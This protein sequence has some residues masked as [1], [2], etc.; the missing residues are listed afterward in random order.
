MISKIFWWIVWLWKQFWDPF[1]IGIF[2]HWITILPLATIGGIVLLRLGNGFGLDRLFWN[3]NRWVR[4]K[5]GFAMG[6]LL[7]TAFVVGLLLDSDQIGSGQGGP[8]EILFHRSLINFGFLSLICVLAGWIGHAFLTQD[9]PK[10]QNTPGEPIRCVQE[11]SSLPLRG[12]SNGWLL[13]IGFAVAMI[14][15]FAFLY[16]MS[17][18]GQRLFVH[19]KLAPSINGSVKSGSL[20]SLAHL[21]ESPVPVMHLFALALV[22]GNVAYWLWRLFFGLSKATTSVALCWLAGVVIL[23][24]GLVQFFWIPMWALLFIFIALGATRSQYTFRLKALCYCDRMIRSIGDAG[25]EPTKLTDENLAETGHAWTECRKQPLVIVCCTGGGIRSAV[26]TIRCLMELE[27]QIP[28]FAGR[29]RLIFGA[30]GGMLGATRYVTWRDRLATVPAEPTFSREE[31]IKQI[32][33]DGLSQMASQ[34]LFHD[35]PQAVVP[36]IPGKHRGTVIEE[37]W[38]RNF[39]TVPQDPQPAMVVIT[40]AIRRGL[41]WRPRMVVAAVRNMRNGKPREPA[42]DTFRTLEQNER[43]GK[44]PSLVYSPMMIEDGRRMLFSNLDLSNLIQNR[45]PELKRSGRELY[46]QSAV[47]FRTLFKNEF[48]AF[49]LLSAVRLNASFPYVMPASS[50]PTEPRRRLVD[51][52]YYDDYGVGLATEWLQMTMDDKCNR[53]KWLK[54]K[55]NGVLVVQIRDGVLNLTKPIDQGVKSESEPSPWVRALEPLAAPIRGLLGFRNAV[56]LFNNDAKL[57]HVLERINREFCDE[58]FAT[59][60]SFEFGLDAS[61]TWALSQVE[62]TRLKNCAISDDFKLRV[63]KIA[64]WWKLRPA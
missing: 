44:I 8:L 30:S 51:A 42:P 49:P 16:C 53:Q 37:N 24:G 23:T 9:Y 12:G 18:G 32:E 13:L 47:E 40:A 25:G 20:R 26:W 57:S 6:L 56:Q 41:A 55:T 4:F 54:E 61:L 50:F 36:F 34:F 15:Y 2:A 19:F 46:S 62:L 52:G 7:V 10:E 33:A 21:F 5:G 63:G 22:A 38:Q 14:L 27:Q 58:Q 11:T 28:E 1:H 17:K 29:L 48:G 3:D 64:E 39:S 43:S 60:V 59:S 35:I 45:G 31:I